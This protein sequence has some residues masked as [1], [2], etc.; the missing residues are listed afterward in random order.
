MSDPE[1]VWQELAGAMHHATGPL[2][3]AAQL[4]TACS[5]STVPRSR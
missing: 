4:C 2:T 1:H 3:A 5:T